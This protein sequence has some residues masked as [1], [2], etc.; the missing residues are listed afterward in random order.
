M[1][2]GVLT[3]WC[4]SRLLHQLHNDIRGKGLF[5]AFMLLVQFVPNHF[6]TPSAL[7]LPTYSSITFLI[8]L[9]S[10]YCC[11][12]PRVVFTAISIIFR[13]PCVAPC[14]WTMLGSSFSISFPLLTISSLHSFLSSLLSLFTPFSL[15][16]FLSS[17]LSLFTPFS[18]HS[19]LS[20]P[21]SLF[22]PVTFVFNRFPS[23]PSMS[24][25]LVV[26]S[27]EKKLSSPSLP[28]VCLHFYRAR[29]NPPRSCL[30]FLIFI[31]P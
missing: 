15:H 18:L 10:P 14:S 16:S 11:W 17:L 8:Y 27:K 12:R 6:P 23:R 3:S 31:R 2:R 25:S 24:L 29:S 21:L 28:A 7:F 1:D 22:T 9:Y 26:A 19:F 4:V 5:L 30:N 20:S 13:K